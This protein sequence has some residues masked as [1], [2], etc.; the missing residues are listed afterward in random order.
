MN[1]RGRVD[2]CERVPGKN[3]PI[4]K[5]KFEWIKSLQM[6]KGYMRD[7]YFFKQYLKSGHFCNRPVKFNY[8]P[9]ISPTF[10][11]TLY[12]FSGI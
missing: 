7:K 9:V 1:A 4:T 2:A 11:N 8:Y 5:F 6:T 3:L 10:K 12:Y